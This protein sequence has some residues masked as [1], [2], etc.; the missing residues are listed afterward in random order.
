MNKIDFRPLFT[1][2]IGIKTG[3]NSQLTLKIVPIKNFSESNLTGFLHLFE[4]L[5]RWQAKKAIAKGLDKTMIQAYV[6]F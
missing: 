1:H 3:K 6:R 2:K 4:P 5:L